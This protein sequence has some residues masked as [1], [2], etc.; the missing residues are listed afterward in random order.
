M[1]KNFEQKRSEYEPTRVERA[2]LEVLLNPKFR[3][4]PVTTI[5][6]EVG[7]SRTTYYTAMDK[8]E[9]KAYYKE[10][11]L[12][13]VE[14]SIGPVVNSFVLEAKKGSYNHGKVILDMAGLYSDKKK[15]E[16]S[17]ETTQNINI[18][19]EEEKEKRFEELKKRLVDL[20]D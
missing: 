18:M 10:M 4:K 17:G 7:C 16:I 8:P 6:K 12:K 5:C 3:L 15:V 13:F 20:N 14:A 19:S 11:C 2:I 9:F 1:S